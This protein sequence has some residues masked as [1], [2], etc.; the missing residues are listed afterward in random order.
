MIYLC[1]AVSLDQ[2]SKSF[3][4][5]IVANLQEN[6]QLLSRISMTKWCAKTCSEQ[7]LCIYISVLN[8]HMI[9]MPLYQ[10]FNRGCSELLDLH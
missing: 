5:V 2:T 4:V 9:N 1:S 10:L 6:G 8:L 7:I 3:V